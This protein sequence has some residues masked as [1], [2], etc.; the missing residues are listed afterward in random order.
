MIKKDKKFTDKNTISIFEITLSNL[1]SQGK[2]DE[3]DFLDR[4]KLLC[5]MGKTVMIT[6]FQEYYKEFQLLNL[7]RIIPYAKNKSVVDY[8]M[9]EI[10]LLCQH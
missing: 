3:Q 4:A 8:L 6:N 9:K 1:T 2:L 5:S 7:L 10:R